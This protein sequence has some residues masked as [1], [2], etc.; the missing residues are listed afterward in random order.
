MTADCG[1]DWQPATTGRERL[2]AHARAQRGQ[3]P[4]APDTDLNGRHI[5]L[6]TPSKDYL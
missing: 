6:I 1:E 3:Q 4:D 2:R 5:A